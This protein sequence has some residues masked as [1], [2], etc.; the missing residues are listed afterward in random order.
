VSVTVFV[1]VAETLVICRLTGPLIR[2][3]CSEERSLTTNV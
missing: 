1:P 3:L 2:K